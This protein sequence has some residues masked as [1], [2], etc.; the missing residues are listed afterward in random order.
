MS[1]TGSGVLSGASAKSAAE[2]IEQQ[3]QALRKLQRRQ[4]DPDSLGLFNGVD[5]TEGAA[6][7]LVQK[8][9]SG[10]T[11][12]RFGRL[13]MSGFAGERGLAIYD[14]AGSGILVRLEDGQFITFLEE[15]RGLGNI[16]R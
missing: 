13:K 2:K 6:Q 7:N 1:C 5:L 10:A 8:I 4:S 11:T 9:L 15:A 12:Q 3:S 16:F 14:A